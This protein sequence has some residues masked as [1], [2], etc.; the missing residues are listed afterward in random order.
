M[1]RLAINPFTQA[2][3]AAAARVID[4][5]H[6]DDREPVALRPGQFE[7]DGLGFEQR[8]AIAARFAAQDRKSVV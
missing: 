6:Q 5:T 2:L 1:T 8:V 3:R 4:G 7:V